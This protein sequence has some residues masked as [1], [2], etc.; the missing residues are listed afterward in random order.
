MNNTLARITAHDAIHLHVAALEPIVVN[1]RKAGTQISINGV[2]G[3]NIPEFHSDK[4]SLPQHPKYNG[5]LDEARVGFEALCIDPSLLNHLR[6]VMYAGVLIKEGINPIEF[7]AKHLE[8]RNTENQ[9][10]ANATRLAI[11]D[12]ALTDNN[13]YSQHIMGKILESH[14]IAR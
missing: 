2:D 10:Y 3:I 1:N 6:A 9:T 5:M 13:I 14:L 8:S 7:Y 12:A 11:T 4:V